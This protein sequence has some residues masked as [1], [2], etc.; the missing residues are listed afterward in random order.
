MY[1]TNKIDAATKSESKLNRFSYISILF[2]YSSDFSQVMI[3]TI[4]IIL[5]IHRF[6]YQRNSI[7]ESHIPTVLNSSTIN[8]VHY[9][10]VFSLICLN[11]HLNLTT[12]SNVKFSHVR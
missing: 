9:K 3:K 8:V 12:F 6:D 10:Y 1:L 7:H 11:F 5:I 2:V 4:Q